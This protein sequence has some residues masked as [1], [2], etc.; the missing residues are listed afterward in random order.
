MA[1][2]IQ[3][4][5]AAKHFGTSGIRDGEPQVLAM[6]QI[7]DAMEPVIKIEVVPTIRAYNCAI[8]NNELLS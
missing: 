3:L 7:C 8:K 1:L 6:G 4:R 5:Q 2:P